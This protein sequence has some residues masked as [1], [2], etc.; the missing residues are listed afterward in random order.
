MLSELASSTVVICY[1]YPAFMYLMTGRAAHLKVLMGVLLV[2]VVTS[3][4]KLQVAEPRP[5]TSECSLSE[6]K[7]GFPSG[8]VGAVTTFAVLYRMNWL[9]SAVWILLV[10]WS[11]VAKNCHT[12][13]QV[14]GGFVTG[15]ATGLG[16]SLYSK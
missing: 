5:E 14:A 6:E 9:L 13:R 12:T 16:W 15:P 11:R 10:G 8:H 2:T 7:Y 1:V 4:L 3:V